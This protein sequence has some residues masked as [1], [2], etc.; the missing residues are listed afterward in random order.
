VL[1]GEDGP[2][3]EGLGRAFSTINVEDRPD[4]S[5]LRRCVAVDGWPEV[6]GDINELLRIGVCAG[7]PG[8]RGIGLSFTTVSNIPLGL[9]TFF[10]ADN[11]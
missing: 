3:R 11:F 1:L 2:C 9:P 5:P 6:V 10:K 7:D 8:G 4:R